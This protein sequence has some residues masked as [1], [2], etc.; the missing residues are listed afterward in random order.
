MSAQNNHLSNSSSI[1][2]VTI[3]LKP[4]EDLKAS[5]DSF[6]IRNKIRAA[7]ILTCV[8][9]LEQACIR[10]ANRKE[11]DTLKR[12]FEIVS[13]TGT[14]SLNGSH[15]HISLSDE[16]GNTT[17]GH[18][19]EGSLIYTTAEIVIGIMPDVSFERETDST[20]GYKELIIKRIS[21]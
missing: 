21:D 13:L 14:L 16:N 7:C 15:L 2:S 20:Y 1:E 11:A 9:S 19:K 18:L 10:F 17:G 6:I 3:R 8:G 5:M 4:G 12:K